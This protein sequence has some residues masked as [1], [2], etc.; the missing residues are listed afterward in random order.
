VGKYDFGSNTNHPFDTNYAYSNA[1]FG[2]FN[3]YSEGSARLDYKPRTKV[4]EW[5]AQD[6]WK[7]SSRLTL[8]LGVRFTWG[9][10]QTRKTGTNFV[11]ALFNASNAPLKYFP[12]RIRGVPAVAV[13]PRNGQTYPQALIGAFVPGT[14]NQANGTITTV[15][16]QGYPAGSLIYGNGVLPA[17]PSAAASASF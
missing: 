1:L 8:D 15:N 6:N 7:V 9:L 2:Y 13:D 3:N 5:F 10:A 14:G 17:L 16:P 12:A 11:P 4:V